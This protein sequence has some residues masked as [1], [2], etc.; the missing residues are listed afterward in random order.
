[1]WCDDGCTHGEEKKQRVLTVH[2]LDG[3]KANL[4]WWNLPALCQV[5]HLSVQGRI[6]FAQLWL[7]EPL[8]WFLPYLAGHYAHLSG[9]DVSREELEDGIRLGNLPPGDY[10]GMTLATLTDGLTIVFD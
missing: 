9:S 10:S 7:F 4:A 2:H 5:C 1:M 6:T 8:A 3:D